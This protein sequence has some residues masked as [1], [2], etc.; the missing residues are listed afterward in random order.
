MVF[1]TEG[2]LTKLFDLF[3]LEGD[4]CYF[5]FVRW[6]LERWL[7]AFTIPVSFIRFYYKNVS[8]NNNPKGNY[9]LCLV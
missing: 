1:L 4:L 9:F 2:S 8:N 7:A 3:V 5:F 6:I